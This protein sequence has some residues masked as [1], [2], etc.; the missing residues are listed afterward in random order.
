MPFSERD[1]HILSCFAYLVMFRLAEIQ[2]LPKTSIM[3]CPISNLQNVLLHIPG[4]FC[5]V[6]VGHLLAAVATMDLLVAVHR[7]TT[8]GSGPRV[9]YPVHRDEPLHHIRYGHRRV[10]RSR[11]GHVYP[12]L[13]H[14]ERDGE[15]AKGPSEFAGRQEGQQQAV[16]LQVVST[17]PDNSNLCRGSGNGD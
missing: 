12:V 11:D 16:Q 2:S 5:R 1:K 13:A 17:L 9:L 3:L 14:M 15:A 8:D 10:L 4:T 6:C 7:G